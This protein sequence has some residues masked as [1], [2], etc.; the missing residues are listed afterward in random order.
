MARAAAVIRV[1]HPAFLRQPVNF[2]QFRKLRSLR[3]RPSVG[4]SICWLKGLYCDQP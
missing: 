2:R 3:P 4:L 1:S